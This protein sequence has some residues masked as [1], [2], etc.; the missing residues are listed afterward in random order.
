MW[1]MRIFYERYKQIFG[2]RIAAQRLWRG[3]RVPVALYTRNV[4]AEWLFRSLS[5]CEP[6][7]GQLKVHGEFGF[8]FIIGEIIRT[9]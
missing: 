7:E 3:L 9:W 8:Q 2:G 4:G 6:S 5:Q 1:L